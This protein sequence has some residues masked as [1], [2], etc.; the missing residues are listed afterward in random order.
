MPYVIFEGPTIAESLFITESSPITV[1]K[2]T[3]LFIVK[4][5]EKVDIEKLAENETSEAIPENDLFSWINC[6]RQVTTF[7]DNFKRTNDI[8]ANIKTVAAPN[9]NFFVIKIIGCV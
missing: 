2:M 9:R 1:N 6:A 3:E 4:V 8:L 7:L 5:N